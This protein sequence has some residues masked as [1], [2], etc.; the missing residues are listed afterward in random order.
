LKSFIKIVFAE[1]TVF[2]HELIPMEYRVALDALSVW[3]SAFPPLRLCCE[4]PA[5]LSELKQR[6]LFN[7]DQPWYSGLWLEPQRLNWRSS[8]EEFSDCLMSGARLGLLLSL[9]PARLLPGRQDWSGEP[10]G[11]QVGG[12]QLLQKALLQQG[13]KITTMQ[14]LHSGQ[15]ILYFAAAKAARKHGRF[16]LADRFEFAARQKYTKPMSNVWCACCA[17][18][19]AVRQ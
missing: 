12:L 11:E 6:Q 10:L 16:A 5:L 17:L 9:L 8:L 1:N 4:Q 14:G 3:L 2:V 7:S 18:I 15:A 19:L 13:F